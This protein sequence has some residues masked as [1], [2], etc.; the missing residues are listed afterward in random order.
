MDLG[1]GLTDIHTGHD[2]AFDHAQRTFDKPVEQRVDLV[3]QASHCFACIKSASLHVI[4]SA[5]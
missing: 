4:S 5:K 3:P 2:L 1:I